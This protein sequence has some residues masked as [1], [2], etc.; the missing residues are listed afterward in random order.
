M[1][2]KLTDVY[3]RALKPPAV[4]RLEVADTQ[5]S[6]LLL[7]VTPN[8]VFSWSV[9]ASYKGRRQ[10]VLLGHY[11]A[12][13][14]AEAR[15][16]AR[17]T[18]AALAR[19][20]S[21]PTT[22]NRPATEPPPAEATVAE[23]W[24]EWLSLRGGSWSRHYRR[25]VER[26]LEREIEPRFGAR[27]L[28]VVPREAWL[29]FAQ[30]PLAKNKVATAHRHAAMAHAFLE[31]AVASGWLGANPLDRRALKKLLPPLRTRDRVLR[32]AE[33]RRL[34]WAAESATCETSGIVRLLLATG[35]RWGEV[36]GLR[37]SEIDWHSGIWELPA[38]RTKT[39]AA[40]LLPIPA[41][42][43]A[44][45]AS[46]R[47]AAKQPDPCLFGRWRDA[48]AGGATRRKR[49]LDRAMQ[50]LAQA[51]GE[52]QQP[53]R[54][55]DIRRTVR[56]KM[57]ELGVDWVAA[58]AAIGHAVQT[59]VWGV[60]D[61]SDP[62]AAAVNALRRWQDHLLKLVGS[63]PV[64]VRRRP[65]SGRPLNPVLLKV[66][67]GDLR[68]VVTGSRV[69]RARTRNGLADASGLAPRS[70]NR[71]ARRTEQVAAG[72][73]AFTQSMRKMIEDM[74]LL[75]PVCEVIM[76]ERPDLRTAGEL[77][78]EIERRGGIDAVL[79]GASLPPM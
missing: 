58:E 13:S 39:R 36:C 53:W 65:V 38:A 72:L 40:R 21:P 24:R 64:Q 78:D 17:Q 47:D 77:M 66:D 48:P 8:G 68:K 32:D 18:L 23:R 1:R 73:V 30:A 76:R 20:E 74:R 27:P 35:A 42:L 22:A 69:E 2:A 56:T 59:G 7:R 25:G 52:V 29:S 11:P 44:E 34:W 4:G 62:R 14:L 46:L 5:V 70:V 55:H 63:S 49:G 57:A 31:Y 16:T 33:I 9:R 79:R 75:E 10:R 41:N 51:E 6:G 28:T 43:L 50:E 45:L 15:Q 12:M 37:A 3:V 54:F 60:Y 67:I 19:G 26:L 71:L 61:R